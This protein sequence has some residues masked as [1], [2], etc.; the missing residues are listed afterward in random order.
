MSPHE[1][2]LLIVQIFMWMLGMIACVTGTQ[3]MEQSVCVRIV[4]TR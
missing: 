4:Q 1:K 3:M 2:F